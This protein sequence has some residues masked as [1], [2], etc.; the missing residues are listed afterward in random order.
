MAKWGFCAS[1]TRQALPRRSRTFRNVAHVHETDAITEALLDERLAARD[2]LLQPLTEQHARLAREHDEPSLHLRALVGHA[3]RAERSLVR[4]SWLRATADLIREQPEG[5][6]RDLA[7]DA[8]RRI[9]AFF[10]VPIHQRAAAE[11]IVLRR[12]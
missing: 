1:T 11:P 8:A 12:T 10:R 9:H 2:R 3:M 7:R 6:R 4:R 5:C